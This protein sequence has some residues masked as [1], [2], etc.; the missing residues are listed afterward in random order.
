MASV[1]VWFGGKKFVNKNTLLIGL[2]MK[3]LVKNL[4]DQFNIPEG[5]M[6]DFNLEE[7][8]EAAMKVE[9]GEIK[10]LRK[11]VPPVSFRDDGVLSYSKLRKSSESDIRYVDERLSKIRDLPALSDDS[12]RTLETLPMR[13]GHDS[14]IPR[15]D[16]D[17][18]FYIDSSI[19]SSFDDQFLKTVSKRKD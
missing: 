4:G 18:P 10:T 14:H 13:S 9:A 12:A 8:V 15:L 5:E 3:S 6:A 7:F 2:T 11:P 19:P 16:L 17:Y 1:V